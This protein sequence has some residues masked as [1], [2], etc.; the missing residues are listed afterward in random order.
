[1]Q[2]LRPWKN[3]RQAPHPTV[4]K[5]KRACTLVIVYNILFSPVH[6]IFFNIDFKKEHKRTKIN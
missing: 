5:Q 2:K 3:K 6:A 4:R 1:M